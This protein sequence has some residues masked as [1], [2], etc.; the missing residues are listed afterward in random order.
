M[1]K[2]HTVRQ[3]FGQFHEPFIARR[4]LDNELK[5]DLG[6]K[7]TLHSRGVLVRPPT[8]FHHHTF[9]VLDLDHAN[10]DQPLV[11][12]NPYVSHDSAPPGKFGRV[13]HSPWFIRW[14][15]DSQPAPP[16]RAIVSG[17]ALLDIGLPKMDGYSVAKS[18][19]G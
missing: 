17:R 8:S 12:I 10:H 11:Q 5:G 1:S 2:H 3:R 16:P 14:P 4:R 6:T 19:R 7:K 13:C 15:R 9:T 18:L